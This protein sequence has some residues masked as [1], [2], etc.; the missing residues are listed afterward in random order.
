MTRLAIAIADVV[1]WPI[2]QISVSA[3]LVLV[4]NDYFSSDTAVTQP[5]SYEASL[6]IY[7][8]FRVQHWKKRLPDW[9]SLVGG[10]PK[11]VKT[12]KLA[13]RSRFLAETRRAEIAHWIQ[14]LSAAFCWTWNPLWAAVLMTT[15]A[16]LANVPCILAQRYNRI[17]LQKKYS[18]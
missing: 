1:Y 15:Y 16:I 9:G 13:D 4:P 2:I 17:L 5:R 6:R 14:L 8:R 3:L 12:H 11:R 7:R 10:E 18:V